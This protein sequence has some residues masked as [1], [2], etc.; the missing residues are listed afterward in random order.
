MK[1]QNIVLISL[2]A[3]L[4]S[5][6]EAGLPG[7]SSSTTAATEA[8]DDECSICSETLKKRL[9]TTLA[10]DHTF[11]IECINEWVTKQRTQGLNSDCP[12][13]RSVTTLPVGPA[14]LPAAPQAE[15]QQVA[16]PAQQPAAP[17]V[18]PVRPAA[19]Q[20]QPSPLS[21][22]L[23]E[24]LMRFSLG[25]GRFNKIN[26]LLDAGADVNAPTSYGIPPLSALI[27]LA[28]Q[29]TRLNPAYDQRINQLINRFIAAG[30]NVNAT[31][32]VGMTALH[33]ATSIP[34]FTTGGDLPTVVEITA[35]SN[36]NQLIAAQIVDRLLAAGANVQA[37]DK[38]DRTALYIAN[39][40]GYT[41]LVERL[42]KARPQ[43]FVTMEDVW[44][45]PKPTPEQIAAADFTGSKDLRPS[46]VVIVPRSDGSHSWGI[47]LS[48]PNPYAAPE[49]PAW[50]VRVDR[51]GTEK[52]GVSANWI[53]KLQN[54]NFI[55]GDAGTSSRQ[56]GPSVTPSA[57]PV[58]EPVRPSAP[59]QA[60]INPVRAQRQID[61]VV[62]IY[63][64]MIMD[65]LPLPHQVNYPL[66]SPADADI[67][68]TTLPVAPPLSLRPGEPVLIQ[69]D[70]GTWVY[71]LFMGGIRN[72]FFIVRSYRDP[73]GYTQIFHVDRLN[74]DELTTRVRSFEPSIIAFGR[75]QI[76]ADRAAIEAAKEAEYQAQEERRRGKMPAAGPSAT[77][78]R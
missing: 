54:P 49:Q 40:Y 10:C 12:L 73:R 21:E 70:D 28:Y 15:P 29:N 71:G 43:Q 64:S 69:Q 46:E 38:G 23:S 53:G 61:P 56:P 42:Q 31:D 45:K 35:L 52:R 77:P 39:R 9:R 76:I 30:A 50:V 65:N 19:P 48:I 74:Q 11:H 47:I 2:I 72:T 3:L 51:N 59:P 63:G 13:C 18:A 75:A 16:Q 32:S 24:A 14:A 33:R 36:H 26:Q 66:N 7:T 58:V 4:S 17:V 34:Q 37:I 8:V 62:G 60:A 41:T 27:T 68:A 44:S 1:I 22:V 6:L 5:G 20:A 55:R 78:P 57:A 67:V 25:E